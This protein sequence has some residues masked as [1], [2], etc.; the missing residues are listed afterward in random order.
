MKKPFALALVLAMVLSLAACGGDTPSTGT[1]NLKV[2]GDLSEETQNIS[3]MLG[4]LAEGASVEALT[5]DATELTLPKAGWRTK[6]KAREGS[7]VLDVK[8]P[9]GMTLIVR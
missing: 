4:A 9:T 1:A 3:I 8:K 6:L 5:L 2:V 7:L